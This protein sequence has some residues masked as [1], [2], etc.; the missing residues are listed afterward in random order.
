MACVAVG[1]YFALRVAG[2][3]EAHIY[4]V[5]RF[6]AIHRLHR[7]VTSL[8]GDT[9]RDMWPMGEAHEIRKR[10]HAVPS[11][12]ERRLRVIHPR[13]CHR[14][15]SAD[16]CG[17]MAP[18]ATRDRGNAGGLRAPRVLMAVLARDFIYSGMNPM[19]ERNRLG[20]VG[21]R[22][23]GPL[24]QPKREKPC[25]HQHCCKGQN[26]AVHVSVSTGKP[27]AFTTGLRL[28]HTLERA[29]LR[30]SDR[31][32]AQMGHKHQFTRELRQPNRPPD[33][34]T[35]KVSNTALGRDQAK[36]MKSRNASDLRQRGNH[37]VNRSANR[38]SRFST[39]QKI[40]VQHLKSFSC[41][42]GP[43]ERSDTG[44]STLAARD[45]GGL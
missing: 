41:L 2:E 44:A 19:A 20:Y 43:G 11:N 9:G 12:L 42:L 16:Q 31:Q 17:A 30:R 25:N 6:D 15:E 40:R 36:V 22:R 29:A 3:A 10:V 14:L 5:D 28:R 38:D 13:A 39:L 7:P 24:R 8:A 23:P 37:P 26:C 45:A 21:S 18:Y 27:S 33:A 32:A 34:K 1:A 35:F 4:L